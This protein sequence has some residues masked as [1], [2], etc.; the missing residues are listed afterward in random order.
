MNS[1]E[2]AY[3]EGMQKNIMAQHNLS[4]VPFSTSAHT[5]SCF[6]ND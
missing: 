3:M 1:S 4:T 5:H 6:V 2:G